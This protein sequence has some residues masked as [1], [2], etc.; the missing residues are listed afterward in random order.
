METLVLLFYVCL[1]TYTVFYSSVFLVN[2]ILLFSFFDFRCFCISDIWGWYAFSRGLMLFVFFCILLRY[3]CSGVSIDQWRG[4]I[5]L[6]NRKK[7]YKMCYRGLNIHAGN[8][9][10]TGHFFSLLHL[11]AIP[12][13]IILNLILPFFYCGTSDFNPHTAYVVCLLLFLQ[14]LSFPISFFTI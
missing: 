7:K 2:F 11:L 6:F 13:K 12:S 14:A 8:F 5:G 10:F 9:L 1:S 3:L 4:N